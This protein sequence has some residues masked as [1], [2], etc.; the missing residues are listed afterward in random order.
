MACDIFNR[1]KPNM[2]GWICG[3][4]PKD[5]RRTTMQDFRDECLQILCNVGCI[6]E[7][8]DVP[9]AEVVVMAR[10][11]KSRSLYAQMAG[12]VLRP[13]AGL[14]DAYSTADQRK[15]AI[16]QSQK[17]SALII[18][19]VG[20]S[21]RHH[22]I[23]TADI[24]G[25]NVSDEAVELAIRKAREAG[26]PV[27]M[28]EELDEA[29]A[30]IARQRLEAEERRQRLAARKAMLIAKVKYQTK[31]INPFNAFEISPQRE[32]GWD[33]GKHLSEKQRHLLLKQ[34]INPDEMPYAQA[35]QVI[36]EFFRRWKNKLCTLKQANVLKKFGYETHNM[37]MQ[38]A[39]QI[40]DTLARNNW[41]K[42]A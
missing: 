31:Y 35:R 6:T 25:G 28:N 15:Q 24:L 23:T 7:G 10:P 41:R 8:V 20:N 39:G 36:Q 38:Q 9:S 40:L 34:G 3:R 1:H 26:G 30:E 29:E 19:F 17:P 13:S 32:R 42:V 22:L 37:T 21:G 2:A 18:D 27:R 11:T 33:T 12:R 14:V 4:T 5:E 16:S